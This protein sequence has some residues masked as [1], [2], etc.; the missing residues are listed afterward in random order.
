MLKEARR[1]R[2][3]QLANRGDRSCGFRCGGDL[4]PHLCV[5]A[6]QEI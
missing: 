6:V 1:F 4:Q 3:G 2:D 5:L